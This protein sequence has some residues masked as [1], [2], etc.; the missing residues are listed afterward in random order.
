M[1]HRDI[2]PSN[3]WLEGDRARV[4][5][6]DFGLVRMA[7]EEGEQL[8]KHGEV[9]GS[10]GYM[11]PEQS[12]GHSVDFRSDLF[13]LG[14]VL[15][16]MATGR[17]PFQGR[18]SIAVLRSIALDEPRPPHLLN[19]DLPLSL[20]NLIV[21]LLSKEPTARPVSTRKVR[22][23][24]HSIGYSTPSHLFPTVQ[25]GDPRAADESPPARAT[26]DDKTPGSFKLNKKSFMISKLIINYKI[27]ILFIILIIALIFNGSLIPFSRVA[28]SNMG[29]VSSEP[30]TAID[31]EH[32]GPA[33]LGSYDPDFP[34]LVPR[35]SPIPGLS[36][37]Q[38]V[39]RH[40]AGRI[41]SVAWSPEGER[42][43]CGSQDGVVRVY[44]REGWRLS[45]AWTGHTSGVTSVCWSPDGRWLAS[46]DDFDGSIRLW[47]TRN[48]KHGPVLR[49]GPRAVVFCASFNRKGNVLAS[50]STDRL[51]RLWDVA[52]AAPLRTL[53]GHENAVTSVCFSHDDNLIAS[54]SWDGKVRIWE[55]PTGQYLRE[56]D[57]GGS[58]LECVDFSPDDRSLATSSIDR[59]V[60][61]WD[62]GSGATLHQFSDPGVDPVRTVKFVR[63]GRGIASGGGDGTVRLWD[64]EH[65][66]KDPVELTGHVGPVY[67]LALAPDGHG[68]ASSGQDGTIRLWDLE[69]GRG[70][71]TVVRGRIPAIKSVAFSGD[72]RRIASGGGDGTVRLWDFDG[73]SRGSAFKA[74]E[75]DV[76]AVSFSSTGDRLATGG[77]DGTI[78]FWD[79]ERGSG[80]GAV[81]ST[82]PVNSLNFYPQDE[83]VIGASNDGALRAWSFPD[84]EPMAGFAGY[85]Q[86]F[87]TATLAK[88][89]A[90]SKNRL[91]AASGGF[92]GTG[93]TLVLWDADKMRPVRAHQ[94]LSTSIPSVALSPNGNLL[95]ACTD[96]PKVLLWDTIDGVSKPTLD[97]SSNEINYF[98]CL[99]F[100]LDGRCVSAGGISGN[101]WV[102]YP[103]SGLPSCVLRG[104]DGRVNSLAF[105]PDGTRLV[106]GGD[107]G[108]IRL[109]DVAAQ[110]PRWVVLTGKAGTA[111][112]IGETGSISPDDGSMDDEIV[113]L[114]RAEPEDG[115]ELLSPKAF[116]S[117]FRR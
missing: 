108:A 105:S 98:C 9:L 68:L 85:D 59:R 2:K 10:V 116:R 14:C 83:A 51:V 107:G 37:W 31:D 109:W 94:T 97:A 74:H 28:P 101:V 7:D 47:D 93:C 80:L 44:E 103:S 45:R 36:R 111:L 19:P 26:H 62:T 65:L 102:W 81:R 21:Q 58:G 13:S 35:P 8:T 61:T 39:P 114:V 22:D 77:E 72:G 86:Q 27:Y 49:G 67:S 12:Q 6:L 66:L 25:V 4:K 110:H 54:S 78:R 95:A 46:T 113:Y 52:S 50:G 76:L 55:A 33:G 90:G 24:L 100:S 89:K 48:G 99:C 18:D 42:L 92:D 104:H 73:K 23:E 5:L 3:I 17:L 88:V 1:V 96:G 56:L 11:S 117:R 112:R 38:I 29:P 75:G 82:G 64:V 60:R 43:A 91:L 34:G 30:E 84:G 79:A 71:S 87:R 41:N 53:S 15:Y 106:T 16:R 20:S 69:G 32:S 70:V 115:V 40:P 57:H 63:E